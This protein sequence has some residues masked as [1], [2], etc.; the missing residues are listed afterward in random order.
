MRGGNNRAVVLGRCVLLSLAITSFGDVFAETEDEANWGLID[1]GGSYRLKSAV[2]ERR[3]KTG[4]DFNNGKTVAK[5]TVDDKAGLELL[6]KAFG[7]ARIASPR[8]DNSAAGLTPTARITCETTKGSFEVYWNRS[9]SLNSEAPDTKHSFTAMGL[10][11]VIDE[12]LQKHRFKGLSEEE[13]DRL[14]GRR[15]LDSQRSD[16]KELIGAKE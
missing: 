3:E 2:I 5:F 6:E 15:L 13:F 9:F 10:A 12:M 4:F 14:S 1:F 7:T 11:V 8:H 16:F